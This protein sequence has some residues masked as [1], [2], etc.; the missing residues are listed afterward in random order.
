M[1]QNERTL[2]NM[3]KANVYKHAKKPL[4]LETIDKRKSIASRQ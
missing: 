3:S 4:G 1:L 2:P